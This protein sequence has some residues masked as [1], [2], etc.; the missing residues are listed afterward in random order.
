[1]VTGIN[2]VDLLSAKTGERLPG[3]P[4][5]FGWTTIT[6]DPALYD[7]DED[8]YEEIVVSTM[9]GEIVFVNR[10]GEVVPGRTMKIPKAKLPRNWFDGT[11]SKTSTVYM[12]LA[13][14]SRYERVAN[15]NKNEE[16]DK[17]HPP[18]TAAQR[19]T[20]KGKSS[21]INPNKTPSAMNDK[22][23]PSIVSSRT[24]VAEKSAWAGF[25]GWLTDEGLESLKLFLASRPLTESE[26]MDALFSPQ[27][28]HW[29]Q[30][31]PD[32]HQFPDSEHIFVDAH[33]YD[34]PIFVDLDGDG[35]MEMVLSV[36]YYFDDSITSKAGKVAKYPTDMDFTKYVAC[37]VVAFSMAKE[38]ILWITPLELTT[39]ISNYMARIYASPTIVDLNDDGKLDIIVGTGVGAV[40]V[41]DTQ[42]SWTTKLSAIATDSIG[43][44]IVAISIKGEVKLIIADD[45][46]NIVCFDKDGHEVWEN[47]VSSYINHAPVLGDVD[48]DGIVDLVVVTVVGH[49][50]ALSGETG[51]VLPNFPFRLNGVAT[52]APILLPIAQF[53]GKIPW[54]SSFNGLTI[55]VH[56]AD[57][58]VYL[59]HAK[60]GCTTKIDIGESS[61]GMILSDD[62]TSNGFIDL[63]ITTSEGHAYCISTGAPMITSTA[64][65][66]KSKRGGRNSFTS[67]TWQGVRVNEITRLRHHVSGNTFH[68]SFE[69]VDE[70]PVRGINAHYKV[71]LWNGSNLWFSKSYTYKGIYSESIPTPS[72]I[73]TSTLR[74]EVVNEHGQAFFD[75]WNVG[76]NLRWYR[77]LKWLLALPVVFMALAILF[78]KD[79]TQ[80]LP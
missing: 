56:G 2:F 79:V 73:G 40:Y 8:G 66:W 61:H 69:I 42:G 10:W 68:F 74:L 59:I 14:S 1:V 57:G 71:K 5:S 24:Q 58:H 21:K 77:T 63:L 17:D 22:R 51:K 20:Y 7:V 19:K 9:S 49:V 23:A 76:F 54:S 75:S 4:L 32:H 35:T 13:D 80:F 41:L 55:V 29:M 27:Y 30:A 50:Y 36:N 33:I 26:E 18:T 64:S 43:S 11:D 47:R 6:A 53:G 16:A 34:A 37:G 72:D 25:D 3:F 15:S 38:Q 46:G 44:P 60:S 28:A 39:D 78:A 70:R 31:H 45:G 67:G 65:S 12:S 62:L 52:S 48:G